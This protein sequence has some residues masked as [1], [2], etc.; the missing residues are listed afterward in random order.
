MGSRFAVMA[1]LAAGVGVAIAAAVA[2]IQVDA[3]SFGSLLSG[4]FVAVP[5]TVL[6]H[7][8]ATYDDATCPSADR[9][10]VVGR[11]ARRRHPD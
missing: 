5:A 6:P 2:P 4:R 7:G 9:C 3:G 1:A 8:S 10:Y 11:R